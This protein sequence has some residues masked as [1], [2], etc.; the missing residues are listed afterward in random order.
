MDTSID[1]ISMLMQNFHITEHGTDHVMTD[2]DYC[3]ASC[4]YETKM[5]N[6]QKLKY[7]AYIMR[8]NTPI[9]TCGCSH[10]DN[11]WTDMSI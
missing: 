4:L 10:C 7:I 8:A 3:I 5:S 2:M 9:I 1:E 11:F 6:H